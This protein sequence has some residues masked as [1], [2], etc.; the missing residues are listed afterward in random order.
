MK[1]VEKY[2]FELTLLRFAKYRVHWN[3]YNYLY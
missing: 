2:F 1:L 3:G